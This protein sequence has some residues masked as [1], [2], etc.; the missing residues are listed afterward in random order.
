ML[1]LE[2]TRFLLFIVPGMMR[3]FFAADRLAST[4]GRVTRPRTISLRHSACS[5]LWL[6]PSSSPWLLRTR[7]RK[8]IPQGTMGSKQFVVPVESRRDS[9]G[10]EIFKDGSHSLSRPCNGAES[11]LKIIFYGVFF[12]NFVNPQFRTIAMTREYLRNPRDS[13]SY[14]VTLSRGLVT[15]VPFW[16]NCYRDDVL[17]ATTLQRQ[18]NPLCSYATMEP[19]KSGLCSA[20]Q[21]RATS[22]V[23]H[24]SDETPARSFEG[25]P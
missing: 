24:C 10:L 17:F 20:I 16:H 9:D 8:A 7:N 14:G 18:G 5:S 6:C 12:F 21:S 15:L 19:T 2:C 23:P 4:P 25:Q 13:V 22:I 1:P 11:W 3:L